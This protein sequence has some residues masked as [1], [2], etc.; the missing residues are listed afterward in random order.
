MN[1]TQALVLGFFAAAWLALVALLVVAPEVY[2]ARVGADD[3][4]TQALFLA[5]LTAFLALLAVGVARR[6]RWT[7][8]LIAVA[9]VAGVL[10]VP[11]AALELAGTL[12]ATGPPWYALLQGALGLV[13]LAIGLLMLAGDRRDGVWAA[14]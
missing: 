3:R 14:F 12:P 11:A 13:Q 10:R 9:F 6:W 5:A 7:F 8:W 2:A 1:R 4:A